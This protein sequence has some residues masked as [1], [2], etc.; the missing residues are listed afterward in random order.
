MHG[1]KEEDW[2]VMK[3]ASRDISEQA[4]G[5]IT[6]TYCLQHR[7]AVFLGWLLGTMSPRRYL[8]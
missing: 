2:S 3:R 8:R 1:G 5:R 7:S 6:P 4:E